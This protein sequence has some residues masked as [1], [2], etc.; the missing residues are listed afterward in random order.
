MGLSP[1]RI[2]SGKEADSES[3]GQADPGLR[4]AFYKPTLQIIHK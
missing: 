4:A 1:D 2:I 3:A